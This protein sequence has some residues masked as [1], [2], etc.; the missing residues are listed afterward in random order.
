MNRNQK[1]VTENS[2]ERTLTLYSLQ[3][4]K[5]EQSFLRI[6]AQLVKFVNLQTAKRLNYSLNHLSVRL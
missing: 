4:T 2:N 3:H 6:L 5:T 1:D